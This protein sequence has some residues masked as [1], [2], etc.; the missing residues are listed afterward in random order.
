MPYP[1]NNGSMCHGSRSN[2]RSKPYGT[3]TNL[4]Y[5]TIL[6]LGESIGTNLSRAG[7]DRSQDG[8][9]YVSKDIRLL[10]SRHRITPSVTRVVK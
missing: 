1:T 10:V 5:N 6:I 9:A 8:A 7:I 4:Y 3:G 2:D